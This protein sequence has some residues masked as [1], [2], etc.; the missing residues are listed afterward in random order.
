MKRIILFIIGVFLSASGLSYMVIY[1]NLLVM[2]Y[3]VTDYLRYIF[4]KMECLSF[5]VGYIL[6]LLSIYVKRRNSN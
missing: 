1:L 2:N 4:T 5:F 3:S 6:I